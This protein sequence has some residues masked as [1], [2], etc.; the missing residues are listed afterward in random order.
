MPTHI[1]P[2]TQLPQAVALVD[3]DNLSPPNISSPAD[4][5]LHSS[6]ILDTIALTFRRTFPTLSELDVR[7]YG[8][9]TDEDGLPSPS[10]SRLLPILSSLRGRRYGLIVRPLLAT[11]LLQ[12]GDF[13]LIGT[14]RLQSKRK[15]QK[16]VDG[17]LGCDALFVANEGIAVAGLVTDDEDLLPMALTATS[18]N[19]QSF[20]W[21]RHRQVGSALNDTQL[22]ARG[23][24]IAQLLEP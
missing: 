20:A 4:V 6:D 3:Y 17:M 18:I 2:A 13:L 10:A 5:Q 12:F 8:G 23:V 7:L 24:Q 14:M 21:F 16:M 15:R 22:L 1:P 19:A 9:W 11:S